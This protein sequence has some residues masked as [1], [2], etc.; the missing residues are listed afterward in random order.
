MA[1]TI[2]MAPEARRI[3]QTLIAK[4]HRHLREAAI[5]YAFTDQTRKK[6][7]K[8]VLG[9][10]KKLSATDKFL[11]KGYSEGDDNGGDFLM[12]LDGN[13]WSGLTAEQQIALVDHE[14]CHASVDY[15]PETEEPTYAIRAHDVEEFA[16]IIRRHGLWEPQLEEF[17]TAMEQLRLPIGAEVGA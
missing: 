14:L 11:S 8:L 7:G 1:A 16:E 5:I 6:N 10:M 9:T 4:Y 2:I 13:E 12:L 3:A 15:D 17:A